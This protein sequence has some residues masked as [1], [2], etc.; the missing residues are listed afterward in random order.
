MSEFAPRLAR[1][2]LIPA[3][4]SPP[5]AAAAAQEPTPSPSPSPSPTPEISDDAST[6]MKSYE[7]LEGRQIGP[8]NMG[9]R[10]AD[11][12]GVPGNLAVVYVATASGG[13]WKTTNGGVRWTPIF[14]RQG[15]ISIGDIALEPGNPEV[16]SEEH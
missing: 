8:A 14:E 13:L 1:A 10:T 12:E 9:G 16:R 4:L 5:A 7:R 2:A 6:E 3:L 15:T 11:V